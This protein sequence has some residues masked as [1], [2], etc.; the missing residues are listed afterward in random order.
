MVF[1]KDIE[2]KLKTQIYKQENCGKPY[3]LPATSS[4]ETNDILKNYG[5]VLTDNHLV[6]DTRS[7]KGVMWFIIMR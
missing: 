2:N 1:C 4:R 5:F 6:S 3:Y 7:T